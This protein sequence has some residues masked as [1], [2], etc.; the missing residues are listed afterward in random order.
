MEPA[1]RILLGILAFFV[2]MGAAMAENTRIKVYVKSRGAKF[3]GSSMGGV[4]IVIEDAH[5]GRILDEG[6]TSGST[7]DTDLIM[8]ME[9]K[10]G[11]PIATAETAHYTA[12]LDLQG[13]RLVTI[14]AR[15]PLA[16]EQSAVE[17]TTQQ[18]LLPGRHIVEGNAITMEM[19]GFAVDVQAPSNHVK[20]KGA[21]QEITVEAN[22][23][24][25]CGCPIEP[26][27]LWDA[28]EYEIRATVRR[29]GEVVGTLKME[30]AGH[31]SQF[32]A[33]TVLEETGLHHITVHAFDP[34][35]GN[36]GLDHAVVIVEPGER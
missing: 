6:V 14:R 33:Q 23:T 32:A 26:G 36:V 7:G 10:P 12:D 22:V 30:Y 15:G 34:A 35:N 31:A 3:V 13:P 1:R 17:T 25:I 29:E 24:M 2:L 11:A 19:P 5:T 9:Q 28:S 27:G 4:R 21:P 20:L 18:W 16:Q 8:K